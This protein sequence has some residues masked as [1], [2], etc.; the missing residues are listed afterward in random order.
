[1]YGEARHEKTNQPASANSRV[2]AAAQAVI[3]A[4]GMKGAEREAGLGIHF[5]NYIS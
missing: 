1:V 4:S 2:A 3:V 5:P